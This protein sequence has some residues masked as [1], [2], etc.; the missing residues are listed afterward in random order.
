MHTLA[1]RDPVPALRR[2]LDL[3][4]LPTGVGEALLPPSSGGGQAPTLIHGYEL[5]IARMLDG[6][7]TVEDVLTNCERIGL[8]MDLKALEGL[9]ERLERAGL[10]ADAQHPGV[11]AHDPAAPRRRAWTPE[12][13]DLFREAL[14]ST[15]EGDLQGARD[16]VE[17]LLQQAPGTDE[18]MQLRAWVE[19]QPDPAGAGKQLKAELRA[20]EASWRGGPA[21]LRLRRP[22]HKFF[23]QPPRFL[24]PTSVV[25]AC[26]ALLAATTFVPVSRLEL[27]RV[28]LEPF[29]RVP[30][31]S[32]VRG[33][34]D[35]VLVQEGALVAAGQPLLRIRLA[36]GIEEVL[37]APRAGEVWGLRLVP[38]RTFAANEQL[39][40]VIDRTQMRLVATVTPRAAK[41]TKP[42]D[43]ITVELPE[44]AVSTVV[45][46]VEG[47]ELTA[48]VPNADR[49]LAVKN[50]TANVQLPPRS[51]WQTVR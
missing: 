38:G 35:R 11:D 42:G 10:L 17:A 3:S 33:T 24:L 6:H 15:R 46:G 44:R 27:A 26:I 23:A 30:V 47:F 12:V 16:A 28:R 50:V 25:A 9:L 41:H 18:A 22:L 36:P 32:A 20:S 39:L 40:Q 1:M 13:R 34:V 29:S 21:P 19:R 7:R 49:A 51:L 43:V 4:R 2:D 31:A 37:R 8:P 48:A 5:S 14:R 45:T